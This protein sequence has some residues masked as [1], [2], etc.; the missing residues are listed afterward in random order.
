MKPTFKYYL[1]ICIVF[2]LMNMN[3]VVGE[4][5]DTMNSP[6]ATNTAI[7]VW[8]K[9]EVD[10]KATVEKFLL[11]AG[12]YDY[13]TIAGMTR[14][15]ANIGIASLRNGK[16]GTETMPISAFMESLKTGKKQPYFEP[17]SHYSIHVSDGHLAIVKADAILYRFGIPMYRNLDNFTLLKENE[18]WKFINLSYSSTLISES[19]KKFDIN[20][21]A[22]GYAQAWCSQK[23]EYV[24]LFYTEDGS[25]NIN[26]GTSALGRAAI[27]QSAKA[28]MDAFPED[29]VVAFDSL[30]KT[31]NGTEFHWTLTGTN[32]GPN[33]TGKK[34]K[35]SGFELWQL[36]EN[37]LIKESKGT[38]DSE[39]YN[40]Q[41]KYG[42]E[43]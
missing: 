19:E 29:M 42:A 4:N 27:T 10:V 22:K 6:Q 14:D 17:V 40:K 23:P 41:I 3:D 30:V 39:E 20:A 43:E 25:L 34:V 1:L 12:N 24:A 35:I 21:F 11:A 33:G 38:F 18:N 16:W 9:D 28:F 26:N 36:D 15:Y 7:Q 13:N 5:P 8:T 31:P 2:S 32:T 37:G